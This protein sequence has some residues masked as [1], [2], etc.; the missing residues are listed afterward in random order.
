MAML[1][2]GKDL[3]VVSE[4]LNDKAKRI[5]VIPGDLL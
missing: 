3:I 1:L 2:Q 4:Y 5:G